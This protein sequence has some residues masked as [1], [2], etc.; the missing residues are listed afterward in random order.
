MRFPNLVYALS[1][2]HLPHYEV[3]QSAKISEWATKRPQR[4]HPRGARAR[5][6]FGAVR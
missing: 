6:L 3:A 5:R 1:L 4:I 2:K